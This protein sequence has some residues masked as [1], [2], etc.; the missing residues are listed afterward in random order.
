MP[1]TIKKNFVVILAFALPVLLVIG[2]AL[3]VY[4]PF[5]FAKTEYDFVYATCDNGRDYY[6]YNC[7]SFLNSLYQ[8]ENGKLVVA[9]VS[10]P[11]REYLGDTTRPYVRPVT[12][13]F[14]H[15][16]VKN[17]GREITLAEAQTLKFNGLIT[18]PDGVSVENGY[19]RHGGDFFPFFDGGGSSYGYYL[20]KGSKRQKLNLVGEDN[21]NYYYRD[22]FKFIGWII[23]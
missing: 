4:W 21:R 14:Q 8:V 2:I 23:K 13:L 6:P 17:K 12:R 15:N 18:S 5:S 7:A 20:T 19:D 10:P 22:D 3:S 1:P 11:K 9:D 16:S